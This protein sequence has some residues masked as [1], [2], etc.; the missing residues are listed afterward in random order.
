MDSDVVALV[1]A[2]AAV[3]LGVVVALGTWRRRR[4]RRR[5][6]R[7]R[8]PASRPPVGVGLAHVDGARR[9]VLSV[10]PGA[11][12]MAID[13]VSYRAHE[14]PGPWEAEQLDE[15]LLVPSGGQAFVDTGLDT[16]VVDVVVAWTAHHGMGDSQGSRLFRLPPERDDPVPTART[17]AGL[18][19]RAAAVLFAILVAS[20]ALVVSSLLQGDDASGEDAPAD[21]ATTEPDPSP[22]A[23]TEPTPSTTQEGSVPAS[24]STLSPSTT[25]VDA[26][27]TSTATTS[28]VAGGP[29]VDA[30][31]RIE[32][33]RF[34][35]E[36]LVVGFTISGFD[37]PP[38]DYTCEFDDGSRFDFGFVGDGADTACAT[39]NLAASIVVE[40]GGVRSDAVTRP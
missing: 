32:P 7:S 3:L 18:T 26:T 37:D 13:I 6:L 22:T 10:P 5:V 11:P 1:V 23:P 16:D 15:A 14:P 25:N 36:C 9:I 28:T 35:D 30:A 29:V 40:V 12:E 38:A 17:A 24:S 27:S 19:G 33:C 8:H 20:G 31:G 39:G 4:R 21:V 2:G 34:A